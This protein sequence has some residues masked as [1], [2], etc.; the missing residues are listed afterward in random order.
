M[1]STASPAA[2]LSLQRRIV[3]WL[4]SGACGALFAGLILFPQWHSQRLQNALE[5]AEQ[6][7]ETARAELRAEE[8]RALEAGT[9]RK[10]LD[11]ALDTYISR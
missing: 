8:Q 10:A 4:V 7:P 9:D 5:R 1:P 11:E 2:H 6:A 3:V